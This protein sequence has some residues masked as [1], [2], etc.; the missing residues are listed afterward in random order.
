M[1]SISQYECC[2]KNQEIQVSEKV[3]FFNWQKVWISVR[4]VSLDQT[5]FMYYIL[6]ESL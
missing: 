6:I 1:G 5:E 4:D 3:D 2:E